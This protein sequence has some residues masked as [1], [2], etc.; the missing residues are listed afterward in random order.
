LRPV[1]LLFSVWFMAKI[2]VGI[3]PCPMTRFYYR[4]YKMAV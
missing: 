1:Q 2:G 4:R 3:G